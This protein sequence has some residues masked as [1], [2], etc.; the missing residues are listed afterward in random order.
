MGFV[1]TVSEQARPG[2]GWGSGVLLSHVVVSACKEEQL[3][4]AEPHTECLGAGGAG[5]CASV[6]AEMQATIWVVSERE[7]AKASR[8]LGKDMVISKGIFQG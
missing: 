1:C 5:P 6:N 3:C 8:D 7:K 2:S 4:P